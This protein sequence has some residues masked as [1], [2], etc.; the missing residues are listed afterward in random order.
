MSSWS[1]SGEPLEVV[2]IDDRALHYGDG[3]FETVAIRGGQPRLWSLHVERLQNGCSRLGID[4]PGGADLR[5]DLMRALQ[6]SGLDT[7]YA[8]V[9]IIV[10]AGSGP[11]AYRRPEKFEPRIYIGVF[12][13][14]HP[15]TAGKHDGVRTIR[16]KTSIA[17]QP[18]LAGIK[19]LNRLEQ[20]LARNEWQDCGVFEGIMCAADRQVICGTMSNVFVIHQQSVTTPILDRCGVA[21]V[22]RRHV[23]EVLADNGIT[24][25]EAALGWDELMSADEVFLTNSQFGVMPVR[26]CGEHEWPVGAATRT[27]MCLI[28]ASGIEEC[29]P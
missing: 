24:V 6:V 19:S 28:A 9:K 20:V 29:G 17:V 15:A 12:E 18:A 26:A 14:A 2:P 10:S 4:V 16:C 13:A 8:L 11:R 25:R 21:G 27:V 3:V 23:L 7:Q 5:R 1:S 22:M